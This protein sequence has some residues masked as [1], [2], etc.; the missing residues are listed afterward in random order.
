MLIP[1]DPIHQ[2]RD[3]RGSVDQ[4]ILVQISLVLDP[5]GSQ[6]HPVITGPVPECTFGVDTW[7]TGR[8]P[9]LFQSLVH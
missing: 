7:A 5:V 2:S 3:L 6:T 4:G 9:T 8:I 1:G